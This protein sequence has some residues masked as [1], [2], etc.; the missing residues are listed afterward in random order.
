MISGL[1]VVLLATGVHGQTAGSPPVLPATVQE[2]TQPSRP[3]PWPPVGVLRMGE[4]IEAPKIQ[5]EVKPD[6]TS[7]AMRAKIQG[8]VHLEAVVLADGTVGEVIVT[9]SLDKDYGLDRSA[10][11][12]LEQWRFKPAVKD[13]V[14]IPVVVKVEMTFS[15]RDKR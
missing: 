7:E 11:A 4:G 5:R 1:V 14:V 15:I 9:R 13:G 3:D 10:V 2:S 8:A 6:Y 12:A